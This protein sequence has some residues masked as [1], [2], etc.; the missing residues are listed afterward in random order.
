[1]K[2]PSVGTAAQAAGEGLLVGTVITLHSKSRFAWPV[3]YVL[4]PVRS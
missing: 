4:T 2:M 1:M 3:G